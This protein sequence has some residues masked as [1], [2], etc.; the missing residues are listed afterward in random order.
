[1][2][3]K[4]SIFTPV[5]N[6]EVYLPKCIE[7]ILSQSLTEFELVLYDDESSD[8]SYEIC[9]RY[10]E[11]DPRI[12]LSHGKHGKCIESMNAFLQNASGEYI[13]F[14]DN[15]D[16]I[17]TSY[18]EHMYKQLEKTGA[19]CAVSSYSLVDDQGNPL[20]WYVPKLKNE[21][22]ESGR[23]VCRRFLTSLD[24]EGFRWNK[25]YR[26]SVFTDH[27]ILFGTQYPAD[28][29]TEFELLSKTN[30]T[31]FVE[32]YGYYYRQRANSEVAVLD[33]TKLAGMLSAFE[34]V[35]NNAKHMGLHQEAEYFLTWRRINTLF[36]HWKQRGSYSEEEWKKIKE[37]YSWRK[38]IGLSLRDAWKICRLYDNPKD[39]HLKFFFKI[40][41]VRFHFRKG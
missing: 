37:K 7:S 21:I 38:Y 20:P 41:I 25:I 1:M 30:K 17:E 12:Q 4:L 35:S 40:W 2:T 14:V 6:S 32:E 36:N 22:I 15:D 24:V 3:P 16:W 18:L 28:I 5:Y 13:V 39:G 33:H 27:H 31:I 26:R 19:D 10:A 34:T 11:K 9:R 29:P 23:E 8:S